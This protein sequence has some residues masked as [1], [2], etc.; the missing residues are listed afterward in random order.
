MVVSKDR[1]LRPSLTLFVGALM[2]AL[3]AMAETLPASEASAH[4]GQTV[5]VEG[6]VTATPTTINRTQFL[7]FGA[8]YPNQDFSAEISAADAAHFPR[9]S[10]YNGKRVE[11]TGT[12]TLYH[13]KPELILTSPD[14]VKVVQ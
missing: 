1:I 7:D 8:A 3:P 14:K 11:V 6:V 10:D 5:T 9:A 12:I 2:T 4:L 13:G